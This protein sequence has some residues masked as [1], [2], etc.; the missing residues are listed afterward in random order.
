MATTFS[1][2]TR[3]ADDNTAVVLATRSRRDAAI[4]FA[5]ENDAQEVWNGSGAVVWSAPEPLTDG[6]LSQL[7][8]DEY[9][10]EVD[11][12]LAARRATQKRQYKFATRAAEPVVHKQGGRFALAT[13]SKVDGE[14][15]YAQRPD[16][17][18]RAMLGIKWRELWSLGI[19][20]KVATQILADIESG[21]IKQRAFVKEQLAL[22][23]ELGEEEEA[24]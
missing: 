4:K 5:D 16:A 20:Q 17:V 15:A 7:L 23:A 2:I 18:V 22:L 13:Y 9:Q 3:N 11:A 8:V 21:T 14:T 1:I 6:E 10:R 24:S 12:F 19:T